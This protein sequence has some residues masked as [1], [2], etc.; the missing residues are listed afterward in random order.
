M[1]NSPNLIIPNLQLRVHSEVSTAPQCLTAIM[2]MCII[3]N[4]QPTQVMTHMQN[5]PIVSYLCIVVC[6]NTPDLWYTAKVCWMVLIIM[7][8]KCKAYQFHALPQ[9]TDVSPALNLK[10]MGQIHQ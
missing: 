1:P 7:A 4:G 9:Y 6:L 8:K 10:I 5:V 2:S 3:L